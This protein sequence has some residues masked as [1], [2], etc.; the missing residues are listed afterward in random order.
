MDCILFPAVLFRRRAS[1]GGADALRRFFPDIHKTLCHRA[2]VFYP[3]SECVPPKPAGAAILPAVFCRS[4]V[5]VFP[6]PDR[7]GRRL[8]AAFFLSF[9]FCRKKSGGRQKRSRNTVYPRACS[10]CGLRYHGCMG[11]FCPAR[12]GNHLAV[13]RAQPVFACPYRQIVATSATV[14][15][16]SER[17]ES[18]SAPSDR[19]LT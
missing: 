3:C 10:I 17:K 4:A 16:F 19:A 5:G 8:C 7:F 9:L 12:A 15:S 6:A 13:L 2:G 18:T 11:L 14:F 1:G